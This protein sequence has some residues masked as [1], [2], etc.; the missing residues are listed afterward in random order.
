MKYD[1]N[2]GIFTEEKRNNLRMFLYAFMADEGYSQYSDFNEMLNKVLES[3]KIVNHNPADIEEISNLTGEKFPFYLVDRLKQETNFHR[4]MTQIE[5]YDWCNKNGIP[6]QDK[7]AI[8][9]LTFMYHFQR[10]QEAY[11]TLYFE[12]ES[13]LIRP[14]KENIEQFAIKNFTEK[15]RQEV[16]STIFSDFPGQEIFFQGEICAKLSEQIIKYDLSKISKEE[17]KTFVENFLKENEI[18]TVKTEKRKQTEFLNR[19]K[20]CIEGEK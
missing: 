8:D 7:K 15:I 9:D 18:K 19:I 1:A 17:L 20:Y 14:S 11:K 13:G 2:K 12:V 4:G 5:Y 6:E 3:Y 16:F 10:Q